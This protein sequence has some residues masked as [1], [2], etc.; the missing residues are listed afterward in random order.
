MAGFTIVTV[1]NDPRGNIDGA[2]LRAKVEQHKDKLGA[3]MARW[4]LLWLSL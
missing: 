3:L 1:K 4:L 2:D